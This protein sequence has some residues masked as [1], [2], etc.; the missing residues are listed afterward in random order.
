MGP[1]ML[2]ADDPGMLAAVGDGITAA[3]TAEADEADEAA[4]R[5]E[6]N[7]VKELWEE[8]EQARDFDKQARAQY[9]VDRR[10]AAGTAHIDFPVD[11]NLIGSFIDVLASFLYARNP[12]VSVKKSPRVDTRGTTDEDYFAKTAE[13]IISK[14]WRSPHTR[15]K[16]Q[17]RAQVRSTLTTGIG[18]LK[19]ILQC[20]GTN[21]PTMQSELNDS[22]KNI[23]QLE[24][25]KAKYAGEPQM[26]PDGVPVLDETGVAIVTPY[27]PQEG[28]QS[29]EEVD[30]ELGKLRDLEASLTQRLEVAVRK[31]LVVDFISSENHQ[32]SLDV[33]DIGD[34]VNA[35]W[36]ANRIYRPVKSL[37]A[38][39]PRLTKE[40][41]GEAKQYF[42]KRQRNLEPIS[43]STR[44]TGLAG[45]D[46]D[47]GAADQY[48]TDSSKSSVEGCKDVPFACI[49]E[50]WNRDTGHVYTMVDGVKRWGKEP[51]Q[52]DYP[53]SRFFPYF[54][55]VFYPVDGSRHP[56]SLPWRLMKLADE[57]ASTRSS[58]RLTRQRSVPGVIFNKAG[59]PPEDAKAI[60]GST[61]AE[62]TGV[63]PT[64]STTPLRDL[65]APKPIEIGDMRLFDTTPITQDM[66]KISG[67][68]EALQSTSSA[69]KTATQAEIEQT[70]F[71]SR[72]TS[73]RDT[74]ETMLSEM[75]TYTAELALG[76]LDMKDATRMAGSHAYWPHGMAVDDLLT[77][78]EIE[79]QAGT[80]GKPKTGAD[81]EAWGVI[82][83]TL[84]DMLLQIVQAK[85]AG[86]TAIADALTA[87]LQETMI[88]MGDE[89]DVL[90]FIPDIEPVAPMP[91]APGAPP[92]GG[93]GAP[94]PADGAVPPV[95]G[96]MPVGEEL[97]PPVLEDPNLQAPVLEPPMF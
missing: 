88:R 57:Y 62:Y 52:P 7:E 18:W 2:E 46:A 30:A 45:V 93:P 80:T 71:A 83:P 96:E 6:E 53:T 22:R 89:T 27:E 61:H 8:Y 86:Q 79:I 19:V 85:V 51:Y 11:A 49:V 59:L 38:M 44:L 9:A 66:E 1:E 65:F 40:E 5:K 23:S 90:R 43:D 4:K 37:A 72:T 12:D 35:T 70:G 64:D 67:V 54:G 3:D 60:S 29:E 73:D 34:Y 21:I 41:L 69:E 50:L 56:Q 24:A 97:V 63:T 68:Q 84:Q 26:G 55:L 13:I 87:L 74:L 91:G 75:A 32:V 94:P 92:P 15:L 47:A 82:L 76:A 42:Q 58:Q 20:K 10:Y 39:F 81:K 14:L 28:D 17:G 78:V 36:N 95:Q 25:L 16:P 48:V 33:S 77:M 31:G